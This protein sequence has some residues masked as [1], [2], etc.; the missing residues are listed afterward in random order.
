MK[1]K[2][3]HEIYMQRCNELAML[4]LGHAAP[5]PMVG[6][7]IVHQGKII[8]EGYHKV[9]G[10]P[11]AEVNAINSVL[12]KELLKK[13]TLYVNLEPCSHYGKTPPC[14][15]LIIEKEIPEVIIGCQDIFE[16][17]AGRGIEKLKQAGC[18]VETGILEKECLELNRR[19]FTFHRLKRPYII[20]KW[21]K[22]LD[23]FIDYDRTNPAAPHI[24][25]ITN[26]LSKILVHKWRTEETAFMVG[27][28]TV[29]NDN[30][31]LTAREWTGRNPL[32]VIVDRQLRIDT[33]FH[34]FNNQA[35]TIIFNEIKNE[36]SGNK[37]FIKINFE[38]NSLQE[39]LD[40]L[41]QKQIQSLVVEG[42]RQLLNSFIVSNLWDEARVFTGNKYFHNGIKE[43]EFKGRFI[44]ESNL[45]DSYLKIYRN[46]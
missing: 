3:G 37:E 38:K 36:T 13:S 45:E 24:N 32:R 12:N 5:N 46:E 44:S 16:K 21:A 18:R 34:V 31:M 14:S 28:N 2:K 15:D 20:L 41:Y 27:T 25:W 6:A 23:G 11:H 35:N 8:G 40:V 33:G 9:C 17:V 22:T 43:P 19:F 4:G 26:N 7:V 42:G 10:G 39:M 30:P 29:L 1:L